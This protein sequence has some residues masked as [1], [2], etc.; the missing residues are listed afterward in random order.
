[1]VASNFAAPD[2]AGSVHRIPLPLR[3][4]WWT[5][6][7]IGLAQWFESH[8]PLWPS[9][10]AFFVRLWTDPRLNNRSLDGREYFRCAR[11]LLPVHPSPAVALVAVLGPVA[12]CDHQPRAQGDGRA[13]SQCGRATWTRPGEPR[14]W[15]PFSCAGRLAHDG[16]IAPFTVAAGPRS[17]HPSDSPPRQGGPAATAPLAL[18]SDSNHTPDLTAPCRRPDRIRLHVHQFQPSGPAGAFAEAEG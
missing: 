3:S 18:S 6:G 15:R 10:R 17:D 11:D 14:R 12:Q 1:M 7:Q 9:K 8:R 16:A 5:N 2:Q 13:M 4:R